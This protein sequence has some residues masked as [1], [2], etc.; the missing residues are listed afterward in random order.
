MQRLW[1][2][3]FGIQRQETPPFLQQEIARWPLSGIQKAAPLAVQESRPPGLYFAPSQGMQI[4]RWLSGYRETFWFSSGAMHEQVTKGL[5]EFA[6]VVLCVGVRC[7]IA[8]K[9]AQSNDSPDNVPPP[10]LI[11]NEFSVKNK[12]PYHPPPTPPPQSPQSPPEYCPVASPCRWRS[13]RGGRGRRKCLPSSP[14]I[15]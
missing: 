5:G 1:L 9:H 7:G 14:R 6:G 11:F 3:G 13:G 15:R 4:A 12:C 8:A 10:P 2:V